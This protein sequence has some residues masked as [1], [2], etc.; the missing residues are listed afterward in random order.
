MVSGK[1]KGLTAALTSPIPG[2]A[3]SKCL[4]NQELVLTRLFLSHWKLLGE[5]APIRPDDTG[6]HLWLGH[7]NAFPSVW[8][9]IRK[10]VC[11]N[12]KN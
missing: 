3:P 7:T 9:Q 5:M 4:G 1:I 2:V 12:Q 10:W 6:A 11:S 8:F